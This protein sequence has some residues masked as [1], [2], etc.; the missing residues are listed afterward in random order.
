MSETVEQQEYEH[1]I[2]RNHYP[3]DRRH[4][5]LHLLAEDHHQPDMPDEEDTTTDNVDDDDDNGTEHIDGKEKRRSSSGGGGSGGTRSKI[6]GKLKSFWNKTVVPAFPEAVADISIIKAALKVEASITKELRDPERHP[7]VAKTAV[8]RRGYELCADEMQFREMRKT[9]VRDAFCR[10]MEMDPAEVHVDDVPVVAFGGSGGGYR[11]MIGF[12]GYSDEMKRSGLWDLLTYVS[13]VSGS[14]WSLAAYYTWASGSM[15]A[16][17]EHCKQRLHPYHPLSPEAIREVLHSPGG[18]AKTLGPLVQ[19]H[20]TGLSTVAM[21]LYSVFT[22]GHLFLLHDPALEP[23]PP[24]GAFGVKKEVAGKHENWFKWTSATP[25]LVDGSEPLPILTAI[26]HERPWKDWVDKEHPFKEADPGSKE[27]EDAEDA[28]FN[29][30]ELSPFEVG[31][32]E[33]EAWC[34]TWAFGRPFDRGR[35]TM[36]IPEQSLALLLGLCTSAPAGPLT[37]YLATIKRSLPPGFIGNSI[38]DMAKGIARMWGEKGTE[39][40]QAHHPLHAVNEHNFMFHLTKDEHRDGRPSP[41]IE[42]SPRIHLIDSGMDNNCPTYVMLHPRRGVDV[43]LNMDASSDVLK[44]SFQERVDQIA[45]RRSLKYTKRHPDLKAGDDPK[46]PDQFKDLYAQIFD[47]TILLDRPKE[48]VDSY[49]HT[50][51]NPPAPACLHE[52]S[53]VYLPLLPNVGVVPDFD[54]STAK[55]SGSYNLVWTAEQ[56]ETLVK[57]CCGNFRAGEDTIRLVLREAYERKKN[58]RL[59]RE[60]G[61]KSEAAGVRDDGDGGAGDGAGVGPGAGNIVVPVVE[62]AKDE[63]EDATA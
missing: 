14:C 4:H 7:E 20:R 44:G 38:N 25:H 5:A 13:G 1:A 6:K 28:W 43:I 21:D 55:F 56:V 24:R 2:L 23:P 26:R 48:V 32:D 58:A 61:E 62:G 35:D 16:V 10:Y 47:G 52:S 37:S 27:H 41:P 51:M 57:V 3:E 39:Q 8:V 11:A 19:K 54:P 50:V 31:C 29:W 42:N 49:G 22:T 63:K 34:P 15:S 12:L 45:S 59:E 46:D 60:T 18:P 30:F 36:Q 17:I 40:F 53:M 33:L 9:K